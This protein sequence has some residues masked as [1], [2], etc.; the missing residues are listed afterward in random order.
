MDSGG[1]GAGHEAGGCRLCPR[2]GVR[3]LPGEGKAWVLEKDPKGD[4]RNRGI[5]NGGSFA[6]C[7]WGG[8]WE[9]SL[10]LLRSWVSAGQGVAEMT[11]CTA[12]GPPRSHPLATPCT[13]SLLLPLP[14]GTL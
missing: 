7:K 12:G 14:L 13:L 3:G 1:W 9:I 6:R 8:A 2:P 5:R 4:A 10:A 11:F